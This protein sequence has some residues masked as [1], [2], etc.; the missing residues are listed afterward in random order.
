MALIKSHD[1]SFKHL[2]DLGEKYVYT[3]GVLK[4]VKLIPEYKEEIRTLPID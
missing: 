3:S 2:Y 4:N 1:K